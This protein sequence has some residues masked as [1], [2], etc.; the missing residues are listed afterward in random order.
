MG[1]FHERGLTRVPEFRYAAAVRLHQ[2]FGVLT[3]ASR[4]RTIALYTM[5]QM[6][7][8]TATT[9]E[10]KWPGDAGF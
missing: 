10:L 1:I 2:P 4:R 3:P 9:L 5:W 7:A 6:T 8:T